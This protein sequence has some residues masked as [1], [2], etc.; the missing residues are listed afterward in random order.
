[1]ISWFDRE[2]VIKIT[3]HYII[4]TH[5]VITYYCVLQVLQVLH[6]HRQIY[7]VYGYYYQFV[8]LFFPEGLKVKERPTY[9][10]HNT[11]S[12]VLKYEVLYFT[13]NPTVKTTP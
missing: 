12:T 13:V 3:S 8:C 5:D 7:T 11:K 10:T 9:N 1:M 2:T 6:G 4:I